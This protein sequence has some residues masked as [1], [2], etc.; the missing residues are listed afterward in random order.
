MKWI[1]ILRSQARKL[2]HQNVFAP[3]PFLSLCLFLILFRVNETFLHLQLQP[4]KPFIRL[5]E[6]NLPQNIRIKF[7]LRLRRD[8]Q[9]GYQ[10]NNKNPSFACAN[11]VFLYPQLTKSKLSWV[12][13]IKK[14]SNFRW[15][16]F[17]VAVRG[18]CEPPVRFPARQFSKLLV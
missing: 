9:V 12:G 10:H 14:P 3:K 16:V 5:R 1:L 17:V 8:P 4:Q 2:I 13:G 11:S 18:G 7:G 6:F 15:R